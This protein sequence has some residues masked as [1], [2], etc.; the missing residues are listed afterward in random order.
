MSGDVA[1]KGF[2][3][4]EMV[5]VLAIVVVITG[6]VIFSVGTE[7]QNSA[8]LRSAQKLSLD[9]R[10]VQSFALS[11][12]TYKTSGVP[13]GWGVNFNGAGSTNYIIFADTA[14]AGV[15]FSP[16]FINTAQDSEDCYVRN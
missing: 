16:R 5:V 7:R 6:I 12:K 1:S 9:L 8:L 13:C 2:S 15:Y 11:M 3:L 14:A 10:R 4:I